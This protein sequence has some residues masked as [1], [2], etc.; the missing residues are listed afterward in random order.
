MTFAERKAESLRQK[1][2]ALSS[3]VDTW[4][5]ARRALKEFRI[6][7]YQLAAL[8]SLLSGVHAGIELELV[9]ASA[10]GELLARAPG[11]EEM[12]LAGYQIWEFYRAK[13]AQRLESQF[14]KHLRIADEFAWACYLPLRDAVHGKSVQ[15]KEPPL[16]Y[17]NA[18]WSPFVKERNREYQVDSVPRALL[19]SQPD[20]AKA[21]AQLPFP[22]VGVPWY[23]AGFLPGALTIAHEVGHAVEADCGLTEAISAAIDGAVTDPE[24]RKDWLSW[25]SEMFAD[26]YGCLSAG[27]AFAYSLA[28]TLAAD[29]ATVNSA[30][31]PGYPPRSLRILLNCGMIEELGHGTAAQKLR[32][33]WTA[34]Y[35][36]PYDWSTHEPDLDRV[37]KAL[38]YVSVTRAQGR[39]APLST[40]VKFSAQMDK[41]AWRFAQKTLDQ[42]SA[43]QDN[44][45]VC[46]AAVQHAYVMDPV[47]FGN[48]SQRFV[49]RLW[50]SSPD[51]LRH[52]EESPPEG[53]GALLQN[54]GKAWVSGSS[55][56]LIPLASSF[57][58]P[59]A[60]S[61]K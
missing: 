8:E 2:V 42:V 48:A 33:Q 12:I 50:K 52:G 15:A 16:V 4:L 30:K 51:N 23:Q 36:A 21:V 6:H 10:S 22:L 59:R 46:F 40:L 43:Q 41:D 27:P 5:A 3:A 20:F 56:A 47:R 53:R 9:Q 31:D 45:R 60:R 58:D 61:K 26:A 39:R 17:L 19:R 28:D 29:R 57:I 38:L 1:L 11:I 34:Q 49:D 44:V 35:P 14:Q 13:F 55:P 54:L 25:A 32:E 24:R 37:A 7:H 18:G